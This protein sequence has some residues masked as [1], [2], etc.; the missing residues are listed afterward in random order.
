MSNG[1]APGE[2]AGDKRFLTASNI[3]SLSRV[4]LMVPFVLLMY[5]T[6]PNARI[7]ACG[8][9]LVAILTDKLDGEFARRLNQIT[10]WGRIIDPLA[11]KI[12]IG[13]VA[14]VLLLFGLLPLWFLAVI[15]FRDALIFIGGIYV[16]AKRGVVLP[17]NDVGKWAV[18]VIALTLFLRLLEYSSPI[19][20]VCMAASVAMMLLSFVLY[21]LRFIKVMK[22][23]T[24]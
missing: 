23:G 22:H 16:K 13:I 5:S 10:E 14:I 20:D 11:D 1:T 6:L 7:W 8:V 3:L 21:T 15:L 9:I 2:N 4:V 17:S 19:V 12:A 18:G 24:V